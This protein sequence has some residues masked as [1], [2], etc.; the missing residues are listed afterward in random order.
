MAYNYE[1]PYIDPNRY[2]SDWV[3]NKMKEV[4][5]I[6]EQLRGEM[7]GEYQ[8]ILV[9]WFNEI[10]AGAT[11]ESKNERLNLVFKKGAK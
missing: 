3:L 9:N 2:N 4:V 6:V 1:Y 11:Y 8:D 7:K 5:N 10:M